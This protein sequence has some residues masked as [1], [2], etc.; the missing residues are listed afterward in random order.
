MHSSPQW[1]I[2]LVHP[3]VSSHIIDNNQLF[4]NFFAKYFLPHIFVVIVVIVIFCWILV[5]RKNSSS[6]IGMSLVIIVVVVSGIIFV[7]TKSTS[8][9]MTG[10]VEVFPE[11]LHCSALRNV[12]GS[13]IWPWSKQICWL[14]IF[15]WKYSFNWDILPSGFFL[16]FSVLQS[17]INISWTISTRGQTGARTD[18]LNIEWIPERFLNYNKTY[19]Y[20]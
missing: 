20:Y 3:I 10:I 5:N 6:N 18:R 9:R 17:P 15:F 12:R 11:P 7:Q 1:I 4:G 8:D 2:A 14:I 13:R 16:S 19:W